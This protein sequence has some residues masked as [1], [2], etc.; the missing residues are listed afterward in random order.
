MTSDV[1][2]VLCQDLNLPANVRSAVSLDEYCPVISQRITER[3]TVPSVAAAAF[4]LALTGSS[5]ADVHA[6]R[7]LLPTPLRLLWPLRAASANSRLRSCSC[8]CYTLD[9]SSTTPLRLLW[10]LRRL[11]EFPATPLTH[12]RAASVIPL[13]TRLQ[14]IS[15]PCPI[16]LTAMRRLWAG[17]SAYDFNKP[18]WLACKYRGAIA[19]GTPLHTTISVLF[20]LS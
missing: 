11:C 20:T 4:T 14:L 3:C 15:Y 9:W 10:P 2:G 17:S 18:Q 1:A 19:H 16:R 12:V 7:S 6:R 5:P 8:R 13:R